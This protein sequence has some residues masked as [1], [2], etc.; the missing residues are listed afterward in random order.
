MKIF[1]H[2]IIVALTFLVFGGC[3]KELNFNG[4]PSSGTLKSTLT[5]DCNP[6]VVN[7]IFQK[8]SVLT[9][10]NWVD[11]QV[12]TTFGG[13]YEITTDTVNG[14]FFYRAGFVPNGLNTIR[15]FPQGKPDSVR[16]TTFTVFYDSSFCTFTINVLASTAGGAHYNLGGSPG[17]C[18][19]FTPFGTYAVGTPLDASDSVLFLVSVTQPGT[20]NINTGAAI[21]GMTFTSI[22]S[23]PNTGIFQVALHGTGTPVASGTNVFSPS[24]DGSTCTFPITVSPG[25]TPAVYTL[26]GSPGSCT[27]VTLAGTY[28]V[29]TA[30]SAANT[31]KVDVTVNT[32]GYYSM[33]TT[34]V[35][36]VKFSSTGTFAATGPQQVT[37]TANTATPTASGTFNYPITGAS[38]TCTFPVTYAPTAPP[39]V[40][41]LN[42]DPGVCN[43]AMV[44]GTY[45][46][47]TALTAS[48]TVDL[49]A[50]VTTAGPYT[51]TT[52]T[53]GGMK[54]TKSG[55]FSSTG[56][57]P[58]TLTATAGSN[59]TTAGPNILTPV[60][61]GG[62]MCS[63]NIT[64]TGASDRIYKFF[65][66]ST[67]YT[68]P[69]SGI[70][71]GSVPDQ[72]SITG[73]SGS[74]MFSLSLFNQTGSITT[75]SYSGTS[76]AGKYASFSYTDGGTFFLFGDPTL[77]FGTNLSATITSLDLI[78]GVVIGTF[79]GTVVDGMLNTLTITNGQFKA[80]F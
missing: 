24:G 61:N 80:D 48:N 19:S 29:G 35:N 58:V 18:S 16:A 64:V 57:F 33:T 66:G 25:G 75:G 77:P 14:F 36:G 22:G 55:V 34:T 27:G 71:L 45:T 78:N 26:G 51:I 72:M 70:L 46:V 10:A 42:G 23:F 53:V 67:L 59:P 49:E 44:N 39:A 13:T 74:N 37:L 52:N 5:G 17:T 28:M 3:Q 11:V 21:N 40:F 60:G 38:T 47:G 6:I 41:T 8:D 12:N 31:A 32:A 15:L 73:G 4:D 79:S 43:P 30:T 65:I 2:L 68:G 76:S 20:Y 63:F 9:D 7:G 56:T 1:K 50:V 69:C 54:F 62:T